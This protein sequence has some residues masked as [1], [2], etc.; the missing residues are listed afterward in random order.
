[1]TKQFLEPP[2][3]IPLLPRAGSYQ[4][5]E[6][7]TV[8]LSA[9]R[10][11]N[12]IKN[13]QSG[14]YQSRL[15]IDLE[16]QTKVSGAAGWIT[17]MRQANDGSVDAQVEW[18][19]RGKQMLTA[20]RFAYISPEFYDS[21]TRPETGET[22]SDVLIGAALTTRPFFKETCLRSLLASESGLFAFAERQEDG[23]KQFVPVPFAIERQE[24]QT[25]AEPS[26]TISDSGT[27]GS[28]DGQHS[29]QHDDAG[30][31]NGEDGLHVHQH[32]HSSDGSHQHSHDGVTFSEAHMTTQT[33]TQTSANQATE[34][35]RMFAEE[36]TRLEAEIA[37]LKQ[38]SES[39]AMQAR[40]AKEAVERS[41]LPRSP[42]GSSTRSWAAPR[43]IT[44]G[45]G[46]AR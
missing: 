4:H 28:F 23:R 42:S 12:F 44:S 16:H 15:P 45:G 2:A 33:P 41:N 17:A 14:L 35:A 26:L 37:A 11:A 6:W 40:E 31:G 19:D 32:Q 9:Q 20:D 39:S 46:S 10:N 30:I 8:A 13:F 1:M 34:Q 27:H 38:A 43:R 18:T 3:W 25:M 7:G 5:P 36:R 21:W 29:H 24:A 22:Y